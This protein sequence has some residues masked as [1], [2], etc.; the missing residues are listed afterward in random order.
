MRELHHTCR[1]ARALAAGEGYEV[2]GRHAVT[3]HELGGHS[4][5]LPGVIAASAQMH[6]C[7]EPPL[8]AGR[9]RGSAPGDAVLESCPIIFSLSSPLLLLLSA[10]TAA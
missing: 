6:T 10:S 5:L 2:Q 7:L 9:A 4:S 8:D 1:L 3:Q